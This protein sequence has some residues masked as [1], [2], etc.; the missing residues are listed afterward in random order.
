MGS[1]VKREDIL[2]LCKELRDK[3][4]VVVDEAYLEFADVP[5]LIDDLPQNDNLVILRTLSKA[6]GLAAARCAAIVGQ[7]AL[8]AYLRKVMA[9]YP[10]P[11][12]SVDV[13]LAHMTPDKRQQRM[14]EVATLKKERERLAAALKGHP[15]IRKIHP[16]ATNFLLLEVEDVP[17]FMKRLRTGGVVARDRR[18][19]WPHAVRLTIGT[20]EENDQVLRALT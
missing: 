3:S 2:S 19:D 13:V 11:Q 14:T 17:A 16:S 18:C 20:P 1:L 6:Y 8:I 9:A 4:I 10:F 12:T 5:S 7:P 15:Q